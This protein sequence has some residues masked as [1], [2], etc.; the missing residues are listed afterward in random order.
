M[1][2]PSPAHFCSY[3]LNIK[4]REERKREKETVWEGG[5]KTICV[6]CFSM[7]CGSKEVCYLC[8][9]AGHSSR[10]D[11][12][13]L[14]CVCVLVFVLQLHLKKNKHTSSQLDSQ[15]QSERAQ[16]HPST[17]LWYRSP[18]SPLSLFTSLFHSLNLCVCPC[19]FFLTLSVF[20]V[21]SSACL[22]PSPLQSKRN[23]SARQNVR[24]LP[25]STGPPEPEPAQATAKAKF[26]QADV[27]PDIRHT[28]AHT[29]THRV[30]WGE[31]GWVY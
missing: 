13:V 8:R 22:G 30:V 15:R 31:A 2:P 10:T 28:R 9:L 16:P 12:R 24:L 23:L 3:V 5:K 21:G 11:R 14:L 1:P 4:K 7:S 29:H 19:L 17:E 27:C 25:L 6:Q 18:R 20:Y 26:M